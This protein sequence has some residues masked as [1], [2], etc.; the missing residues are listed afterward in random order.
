M[1]QN[2]T[3]HQ[4]VFCMNKENAAVG[5]ISTSLKPFYDRDGITIFCGDCLIV[6]PL[7]IGL[8]DAVLADLP[9]G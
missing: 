9:Y 6:M 1:E 5:Q 4:G 7:L 2:Q 3:K 8:F